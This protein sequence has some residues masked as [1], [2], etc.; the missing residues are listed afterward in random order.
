MVKNIVKPLVLGMGLILA[1]SNGV[2]NAKQ[3][4]VKNVIKNSSSKHPTDQDTAKASK[5]NV[6]QASGKQAASKVVQVAETKNT[7]KQASSKQVAAK[8][9]QVAVT[10]SS[11]KQIAVKD[12]KEPVV[13]SKS[14]VVAKVDK[15]VIRQVLGKH[16]EQTRKLTEPK[17]LAN[18][19]SNKH[20]AELAS[21]VKAEQKAGHNE[22]FARRATN[23]IA[24]R[25][26]YKGNTAAVDV[27]RSVPTDN[28]ADHAET[29]TNGDNELPAIKKHRTTFYKVKRG[30]TVPS[31]FAD[32][33]LNTY[34]LH[35]I[36][37]NRK[38]GRQ[39]KNL[40]PGKTL[41]IN[42]NARGELTS[43]AYKREEVSDLIEESVS[44]E[45]DNATAVSSI[46]PHEEETLASEAS[47]ESSE[48][49]VFGDVKHVSSHVIVQSSLEQAGRNAG[50]PKKITAQ[51]ANIFA[52][53]IDFAQNLRPNDQFTVV[54]E[55]IFEGGRAVD[56]GDIV[57][58][59]FINQGEKHQ[60]VRYRDNDGTISY[61]TPEGDVMRRAFLRNPLDFAKVSS[62]FNPAR[63]HPVLNR[64]RAHKGVDYAASTG[65]P[66]KSTGDGN[67]SFKGR[68]GG[69]GQVVTIQHGTEYTTLYG[70]L[71][72]F[73]EDLNEGDSVKQGQVIGYVGQTGLATGPHLHYEFL[74]NGVHKDPLTVALPHSVPI[75]RALLAYF[76]TQTRPLLAQLDQARSTMVARN[77]TE[78]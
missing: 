22:S 72:A 70:H 51:L 56:T 49:S 1:T 46:T 19:Q 55:K 68:K 11:V 44:P 18:S 41:S 12:K 27:S 69:Y 9:V 47:T 61:F 60:A 17:A 74:V 38:L 50:L 14:V 29:E 8:T 7:A 59:E 52:W 24:R 10:K 54:Y 3:P 76:K 21:S 25:G 42:T 4:L 57:A 5:N 30:D 6:K 37:H 65:T 71:S 48:A 26:Y 15:S 35:K 33:N 34:D 43:L 53:D 77:M 63:R 16:Q 66:I 20:T 78:E 13:L 28:S 67:V 58:A 73:N 40:T 64:I 75:N 36:I 39:F 31:I 32:L 23:T 2:V 45:E 62:L